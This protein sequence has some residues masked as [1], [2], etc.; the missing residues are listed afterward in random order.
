MWG[1]LVV[2]VYTYIWCDVSRFILESVNPMSLDI[3]HGNQVQFLLLLF[4]SY[5]KTEA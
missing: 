1:L 4:F 2:Y 3:Y 5:V